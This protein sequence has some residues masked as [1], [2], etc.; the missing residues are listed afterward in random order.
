MATRRPSKG[1][2]RQQLRDSE[3]LENPP[4]VVFRDKKGQ[5]VK[6]S[7]RY[8][9]PVDVYTRTGPKG[10]RKLTEKPSKLNE[11]RLATI[12]SRP[13]FDSLEVIHKDVGTFRSRRKEAIWDIAG[14]I[15]T[16]KGV[17]RSHLYVEIHLKD[18]TGRKVVIEKQLPRIKQ[19]TSARAF[20]ASV[21]NRAIEGEGMM[22][23]DR[24]REKIIASRYGLEKA[25]VE[26]IVLTK[27]R[28]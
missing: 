14:E 13:A 9:V 11:H 17:R 26:K 6:Q 19:N 21:L 1:R 28:K 12:L 5:F 25:K 18:K 23:Y 8:R 2:L 20:I 27:A 22:I 10:Y 4:K 24:T 16:T 15:D 3:A 7:D